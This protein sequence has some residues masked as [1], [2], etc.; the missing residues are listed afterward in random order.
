MCCDTV[1]RGLAYAEGKL[2]LGQADNTLIALDAETGELLWDANN[3]DH[4]KGESNTMSPLVVHDKVIVGI[5]GGEFGIR[6]H[7]T[8]YDIETGEMAWRGYSNGPDEEVLIDPETTLMMGNPIGE[9]DLGVSTWP[10][11]EWQHGG[12]APWGWV[13]YDPELDLIYYGTGNPG[14]LNP[15]SLPSMVS[16]PTTNG[17]LPFL[18]VTPTLAKL[19]GSIRRFPS[20]SGI[21][22]ASTKTS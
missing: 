7:M 10:E 9:A 18:H 12:G 22:M 4:T 14:N 21:T 3:G 6:G 20:T 15:E 1:N 13:T 19:N 11:D 5:S 17:R 8:A 16:L 2:F